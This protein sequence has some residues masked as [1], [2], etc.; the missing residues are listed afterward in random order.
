MVGDPRIAECHD[1]GHP[2]SCSSDYD[3]GVSEPSDL[4]VRD[5]E[6][7][8][9]ARATDPAFVVPEEDPPIGKLPWVKSQ[10]EHNK[11]SEILGAHVVPMLVIHQ[12]LAY[13]PTADRINA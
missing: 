4:R 6:K 10:A 9:P 12:R 13:P 8:V 1:F 3:I 5:F 2:R 11:L 7:P